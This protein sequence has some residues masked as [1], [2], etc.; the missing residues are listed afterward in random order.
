METSYLAINENHTSFRTCQVYYLI[1]GDLV[2]CKFHEDTKMGLSCRKC[3][4]IMSMKSD[5]GPHYK[6]LCSVWGQNFSSYWKFVM[7]G[8]DQL[9]ETYGILYAT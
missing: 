8:T 6:S 2:T 4:L 9:S 1:K 7:I 3:F 5:A